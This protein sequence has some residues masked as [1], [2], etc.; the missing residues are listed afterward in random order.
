MYAEESENKMQCTPPEIT[1]AAKEVSIN[2]LPE[3]SRKNY[4]IVY[5]KFNEWRLKN[6]TSSFSEDTVL[7]Y[8]KEISAKFKSSTLWTHYSML[9]STLKL[10]HNVN[11]E[12]YGRVR[13]LLKRKAEGYRAKKSE[14]FTGE[15]INI[16]I[17]EAPDVKYLAT[18]VTIG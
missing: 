8:F 3:K 16:F 11:I 13:A 18:K 15:Q 9:K 14:V 10:K 17:K 2:L 5:N 6:K 12:P 1:N 7:V 4:E